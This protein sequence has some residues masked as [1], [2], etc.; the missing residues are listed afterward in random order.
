M[1]GIAEDYEHFDTDIIIHINSV[2]AILKQM[3]V[4]PPEGF[5]I[6]DDTAVWSDFISEDYPEFSNVKTYVYLKVKL[7]FDSS[8]FGSPYLEAIGNMIKELEW[9]LHV[10]A[11]SQDSITT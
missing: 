5:T 8:N 11:E 7:I 10:A 6:K 2:L 3:G 9:R 4:G 1:L